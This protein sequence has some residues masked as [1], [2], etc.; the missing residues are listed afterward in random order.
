MKTRNQSRKSFFSVLSN[1]KK[2]SKWAKAS[3]QSFYKWKT[4]HKSN[5]NDEPNLAFDLKKQA[6]TTPRF[7]ISTIQ[8]STSKPNHS[9]LKTQNQNKFC[10]DKHLEILPGTTSSGSL[11]E[12][13]WG[14]PD[15]NWSL[16]FR[17]ELETK[18]D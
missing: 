4:K 2:I 15:K 1:I 12:W 11:T 17:Q 3:K 9:K 18:E 7:W 10:N 16:D 5:D 14:R 8:I 13:F 6:F